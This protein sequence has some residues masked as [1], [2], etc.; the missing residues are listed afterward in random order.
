M[1]DAKV[2]LK[3]RCSI[4]RSCWESPCEA[5]CAEEVNV[6]DVTFVDDE[7]GMITAESPRALNVAIYSVLEAFVEV[8]HAVGLIIHWS[9]GKSEA[10]LQYRGKHASD[11][12]DKRRTDNGICI[13]VLGGKVLHVVTAYKHLGGI[14]NI[15][16]DPFRSVCI[17]PH[18]PCLPTHP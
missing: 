11:C 16:E 3:L 8:F 12:L 13:Q 15:R 2:V 9:K 17:E 14:V 10:L 1:H 18:R 5:D 6:V 7:A 4:N